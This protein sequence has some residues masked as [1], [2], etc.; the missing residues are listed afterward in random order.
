MPRADRLLLILGL[1]TGPAV[2]ADDP[3]GARGL[4]VAATGGFLSGAADD[5]DGRDAGTWIG[6]G[7]GLRVGEEIVDGLTLGLHFA[8]GW[9]NANSGDYAL[10]FGGMLVEAGYRP[11]ARWPGVILTVGTGLGGGRLSGAGDGAP[12]GAAV[13]AMHAL[14]LTYELPLHDARSGDEVGLSVAP[15][16]RWVVVPGI[17][18]TSAAFHLFALGVEVVW[19][20]GR[21]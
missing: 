11:L 9:G 3:P 17:D 15:T 1:A 13:G 18:D 16:F 4:F 5:D 8:G 20:A 2:A 6:A 19:Y 21:W 12:D 7:G 10:G 14:G